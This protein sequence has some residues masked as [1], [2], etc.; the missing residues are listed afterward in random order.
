MAAP[1][2]RTAALLAAGWT[3]FV[4]LTR[5]SNA[6]RDDDLGVAA[7]VGALA[8]AVSFLALAVVV[9]VAAVRRRDL[10]FR[11]VLALTVWTVAVWAV[12]MVDI[13]GSDHGIGF[14][15]VHLL[16]AVVSVAVCVVALLQL[17]EDRRGFVGRHP[18][19]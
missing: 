1:K 10:L 8:V 6:V 19:G 12:R 11:A 13:A 16:L 15:V 3:A 4:W 18:D 17:V 7:T 14:V 2:P 5:V 9:V